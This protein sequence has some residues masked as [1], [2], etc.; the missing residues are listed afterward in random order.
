MHSIITA[1]TAGWDHLQSGLPDTHQM[2]LDQ[3]NNPTFSPNSGEFPDDVKKKLDQLLGW[4]SVVVTAVCIGG[5]FTVAGKMAINHK[6]G[7]GGEHATGL[8]WVGAACLLVGSAATL[9]NTL[10]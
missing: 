7:E 10:I 3:T 1:L 8:A 6:R 5:L 9:V 2:L 4:V